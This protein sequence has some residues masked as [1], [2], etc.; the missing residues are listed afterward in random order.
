MPSTKTKTRDELIDEIIAKEQIRELAQLYCRADD[1]GDLELMAKVYHEDATDSHGINTSGTLEEY[2]DLIKK[3][4]PLMEEIQH[5]TTNHLI[6]V[7]GDE[8]EGEAYVLSYLGFTNET[9]KRV[10]I[11]GGRY[12]DRYSK[13]EGTWRI[14]H[15]ECV[16]D[17]IIDIPAPEG[18]ETSLTAGLLPK[19]LA[20]PEDVSY[21]FLKRLAHNAL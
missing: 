17:W 1:R 5:H 2:F 15:R 21:S 19:G 9:G 4:R 3:Y 20:K 12:L 8:A 6:S 13:R 10:V 18:P 7:D 14:A 11:Q 16:E